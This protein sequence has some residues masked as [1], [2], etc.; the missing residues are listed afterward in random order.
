M[1][2]RVRLPWKYLLLIAVFAIA[3]LFVV[4]FLQAAAFRRESEY[5]RYHYD[6][7]ISAPSLLE[8][9][10]LLLPV[11]SVGNKSLLG[12]ALVRGEGYSVPPGWNLSL[13]QVNDTPVLGISAPAIVPGYH[14]YPIRVEPGG[15]PGETPPPAST[16]WS[17][18]T[19]VL[20]PI[21]FGVA[22]MVPESIGT[23]EPVGREPLL[24]DPVY[25]APAPCRGPAGSA[26]CYRYPAPVF[27]QCSP[28]SAG[29]L[30]LS[31]SAG[32]TNQ[33][34]MGGWSGNSYQ[35]NIG[36]TLEDPSQGWIMADGFLSTGT[37]RS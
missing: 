12:E 24:T 19:P 7:F 8:N 20:I 27:V 5:H 4:V 37:G 17:Q 18:G 31:I 14:G 23:R 3:L 35:E 10:T 2:K 15:T 9:C 21:D 26:H 30:T 1:G 25:L 33:W 34:W 32:G 11:P 29:N 13:A 28:G 6:V 22:L 16:T 36:V